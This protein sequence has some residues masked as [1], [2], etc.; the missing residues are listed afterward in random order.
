MAAE[1]NSAMIHPIFRSPGWK[2]VKGTDEKKT[3]N[4]PSLEYLTAL[5]V[6]LFKDYARLQGRSFTSNLPEL[7]NIIQNNY[8]L[9]ALLEIAAEI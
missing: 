2:K 5:F 3:T 7:L 1:G 6:D 8:S 9:K 4:I